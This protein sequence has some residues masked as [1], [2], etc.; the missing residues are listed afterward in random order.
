M[1]LRQLQGF[2]LL[3]ELFQYYTTTTGPEV[4]HKYSLIDLTRQP[5]I[6]ASYF[7]LLT[8]NLNHNDVLNIR[9]TRFFNAKKL[10]AH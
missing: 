9:V 4:I 5:N 2:Q 8:Q 6:E 10:A 1:Y 7:N 3:T